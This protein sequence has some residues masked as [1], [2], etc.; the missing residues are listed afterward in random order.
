[1]A[2]IFFVPFSRSFE[3]PRNRYGAQIRQ[4]KHALQKTRY[5]CRMI[6]TEETPGGVVLPQY[7]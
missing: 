3:L 7:F 6:G 5:Q 2:I 4:N 1:M